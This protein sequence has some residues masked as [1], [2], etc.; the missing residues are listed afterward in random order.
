MKTIGLIGGMSWESTIP[1]YSLINEYI[2]EQLGGFHS[3]KMLIYN[4]DFS[5]LEACLTSGDWDTITTILTDAA[6]RL[7]KGG[8]DFILICTNTMHNVFDRVQAGVSVPLVHIADA[9]ADALEKDGVKK[10]ALLGTKYTMTKDFYVSR[11]KKRDFEVFIPEGDDIELVNDIIFNEL[12][13]GE[14]KESSKAEYIRIIDGLKDKGAE[15]VIF[16]CTEIGLLVPTEESPL[17]AYDTTVIHAT[18]AAELS[19]N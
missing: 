19:L 6:Q 16:G 17:P 13:L 14:V 10:V 3:A 5:E 15:A 9:A 4:V 12:C 11:L 1:Y 7:E 18:K 2:K 8:A